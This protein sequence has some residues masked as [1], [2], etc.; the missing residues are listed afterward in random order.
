MYNLIDSLL[1]VGQ[2]NGSLLCYAQFWV[3]LGPKNEHYCDP[4]M[5]FQCSSRSNTKNRIKVFSCK[6]SGHQHEFRTFWGQNFHPKWI[7][8]RFIVSNLNSPHPEEIFQ[9]K[10]NKLKISIKARKATDDE[11]L[12]VPIGKENFCF[13]PSTIPAFTNVSSG[14][15]KSKLS[16]IIYC[17]FD[18]IQIHSHKSRA[19]PFYISL[20]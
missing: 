17:S 7:L 16:A 4:I 13:V 8:D 5:T 12:E 14:E 15:R 19:I 11:I 9:N 18:T 3:H 6:L 2:P 1:I 10:L 20:R